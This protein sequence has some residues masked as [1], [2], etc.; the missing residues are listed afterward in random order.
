M[1]I[2]SISGQI[3]SGKSFYQLKMTLEMA[4]MKEKQIVAN[5]PLNREALKIYCKEMGFKWCLDLL[6]YGGITENHAPKN[7]H[8]LLLPQS[9]VMLDEAGILIN[10]RNW[11]D[12]PRGFLADLCQ[13]RKRG[14]DLIWAAQ[15][16]EQVD[17]QMRMLTQYWIH[18]KGLTYYCKKSR[19]PRMYYKRYYYMD[20]YMN[21][22]YLAKN[23]SHIKTRLA[24]AYRYHGGFLDKR[25]HMLFECFNSLEMIDRNTSGYSR[26]E[27]LDYCKLDQ[28]PL[29]LPYFNEYDY[30]SRADLLISS[31]SI[32][33]S[34]LQS[35]IRATRLQFA[36]F[37]VNNHSELIDLESQAMINI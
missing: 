30:E 36:D 34:V 1:S 21:Q 10:S 18:A 32:S 29:R 7:L 11:K 4:E 13:S 23:P 16:P 9:V 2:Y 31:D 6:A 24:F 27:S 19:L 35:K 20:A 37:I 5:F 14:T 15:F 12:T 3:G 8:E 17:S 22:K 25:D 26:Y 33:G 28:Q